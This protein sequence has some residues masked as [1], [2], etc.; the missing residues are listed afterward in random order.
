MGKTTHLHNGNPARY[1]LNIP[2]LDYCILSALLAS[3]MRRIGTNDIKEYY[4]EHQIKSPTYAAFSQALSRLKG[5]KILKLERHECL[6]IEF[7]NPTV[8]DAIE[9]AFKACK[10]AEEAIGGA[11]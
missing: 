11:T 8:A 9:K 6:W 3:K 5:R 4:L 1:M 2:E 10:E 7:E